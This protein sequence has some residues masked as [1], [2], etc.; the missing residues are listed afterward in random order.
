MNETVIL[1]NKNL[2]ELFPGK[3]YN[4]MDKQQKVQ[5][6]NELKVTLP[7]HSSSSSK[8]KKQTMPT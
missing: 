8:L 7:I 5:Y 4:E 6:S 3:V 2:I 1:F